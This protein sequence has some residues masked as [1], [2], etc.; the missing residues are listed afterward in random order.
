MGFSGWVAENWFDLLQSVGIISGLLFTAFSLRSETKTRRVSNLLTITKNHR[1]I[2]MEFNRQ[3]GL[4]R[5]LDERADVRQKD[6]TREEEIFVNFIILHLNSTFYAQKSGLVFKLEGLRR[7]I[8][9]F[10]SLPIPRIIWEKTKL[11]QNDDF[12][13]FVEACQNWK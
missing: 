5:V 3:P 4:A 13:E 10:F 11:L 8:S 7:D 6:I 12:V 2:W 1:K 9:W